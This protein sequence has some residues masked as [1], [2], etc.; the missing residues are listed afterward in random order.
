MKKNDG[1]S[2]DLKHNLLGKSCVIC[3]IQRDLFMKYYWGVDKLLTT[4]VNNICQHNLCAKK[5]N[6]FFS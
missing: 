4:R 2:Q 1:K 5:Q 3:R 6:L